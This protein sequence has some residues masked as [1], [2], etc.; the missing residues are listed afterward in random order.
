MDSPHI[1][2]M[3]IVEAIAGVMAGLSVLLTIGRFVIRWQK[4]G[5][6]YWDDILNGVAAVLVVVYIISAFTTYVP[7]QFE[8]RLWRLGL[9]D[10]EPDDTRAQIYNR[11]QLASVILFWTIIYIV[12]AS[13]L[14]LYWHLFEVSVRFRVAWWAVAV[15][16][17]LSYAVTIGLFIWTNECE[18]LPAR[19]YNTVLALWC[20]LNVA[21]GLLLMAVPI[22]MVMTRMLTLQP[23]QKLGLCLIFLIGML[24][25]VFDILRTS[26]ALKYSLSYY[27]NL[28]G[29]WTI[30]EPTIAVIV[31][32]LP[33][34]K[35]IICS[36]RQREYTS[37]TPSFSEVSLKQTT[38]P[39]E[40][41]NVS[42]LSLDS[43]P[44]QA[45]V[46]C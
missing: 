21:G 38:P 34:Y 6:L 3:E 36:S 12:K 15:F 7:Y 44:Q 45:P 31:C 5:R 10:D 11:F 20:G 1:V 4:L 42:P 25:L 43:Q 8:L 24:D 39:P 37:R 9:R 32:T 14:A 23:A 22:C 30:L 28:S 13:F 2:R 29:L 41:D 26:W 19:I 17:A 18:G 40:M 46:G 27:S 16:I 33:H 35:S